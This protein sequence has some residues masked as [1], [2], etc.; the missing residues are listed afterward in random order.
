MESRD[1][2]RSMA[3]YWER[4]SLVGSITCSCGG[5]ARNVFKR[6]AITRRISK[7]VRFGCPF[8]IEARTN[9]FFTGIRSTGLPVFGGTEEDG[10]NVR[11]PHYPDRV[12][13]MSIRVKLRHNIFH[14][15]SAP[16]FS[17]TYRAG[18]SGQSIA[19]RR[20]FVVSFAG[21]LS[22]H[23]ERGSAE[24]QT[25]ISSPEPYAPVVGVSPAYPHL[26]RSRCTFLGGGTFR[27]G[28]GPD[29]S[30]PKK[31][32]PLE[33]EP[34]LRSIIFWVGAAG[35]INLRP[36]LFTPVTGN[37]F[38]RSAGLFTRTA[39]VHSGRSFHNFKF[40]LIDPTSGCVSIP[41]AG[42]WPSH[43]LTVAMIVTN[44][45][46]TFWLVMPRRR[47]VPLRSAM[48]RSR[49][50]RQNPKD[51]ERLNFPD[52]ATSGSA[53]F[54]FTLLAGNENVVVSYAGILNNLHTGC[55]PNLGSSA[56]EHDRTI[57]IH[58]DQLPLPGWTVLPQWQ[59]PETSRLLPVQS[60][61]QIYCNR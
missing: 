40:R 52:K 6:P 1:G 13:G 22:I 56:F 37:R 23:P 5:L 24:S 36:V 38:V 60:Y 39:S 48:P 43:P 44:K 47:S 26:G 4:F 51:S 54:S 34:E 21:I 33:N 41:A 50:G 19:S 17:D 3:S 57:V 10:G 8:F 30:T 53:V 59:D 27:S 61:Y 20:G 28:L 55:V 42:L 58:E 31:L 45:C 25:A 49:V 29:R 18:K 12:R 11:M 32:S 16:F 14:D 15:F 7:L 46:N 35:P 2:V 9:Y